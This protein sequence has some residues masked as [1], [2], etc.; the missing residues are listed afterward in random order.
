MITVIEQQGSAWPSEGIPPYSRRLTV[1]GTLDAGLYGRS[2]V[3]GEAEAVEAIGARGV[4]ALR[5]LPGAEGRA[6]AL[7]LSRENGVLTGSWQE[8]PGDTASTC[9]WQPARD[10]PAPVA[11]EHVADSA[12]GRIAQAS[13]LAG[14]RE[15]PDRALARERFAAPSRLGE[16]LAA[17]RVQDLAQSDAAFLQGCRAATLNRLARAL[18][19]EG[20]TRAPLALLDEEV[21]ALSDTDDAERDL[22]SLIRDHAS[23]LRRGEIDSGSPRPA[24]VPVGSARASA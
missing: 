8:T 15:D 7:Q 4:L 11:L 24:L 21:A 5:R 23:E 20:D 6:G 3:S 19:R 12:P 18:A 10:G 22:D 9:S 13:R 2:F 14:E 16:E 1:S 17:A